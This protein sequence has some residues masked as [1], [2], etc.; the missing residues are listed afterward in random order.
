VR[1]LLSVDRSGSIAAA[2]ETV[3]LAA[4]FAD[5]ARYGGI[6]VGLD[7]SGVKLAS[8]LSTFP[9]ERKLHRV[10]PNCGPTLGL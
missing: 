4:T 10:G 3:Q 1:L 7:F 6:V 9:M 8:I 2:E 5:D